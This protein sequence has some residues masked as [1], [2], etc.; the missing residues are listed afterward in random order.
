MIARGR[1]PSGAP[2]YPPPLWRAGGQSMAAPVAPARSP[3]AAYACPG[4]SGPLRGSSMAARG[5]PRTLRPLWHSLAFPTALGYWGWA[6]P[7]GRRLPST[8][9]ADAGGA[10][11]L[12]GTVPGLLGVR[13]P[14]AYRGLGSRRPVGGERRPGWCSRREGRTCRAT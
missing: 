10:T 4:R 11:T 2:S 6:G 13:L 12:S 8:S 3:P 1:L 5:S 14:R 9:L 7:R